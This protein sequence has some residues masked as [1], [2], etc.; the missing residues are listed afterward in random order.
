MNKYYPP[1]EPENYYHIYNHAVGR[2]NIFEQ[3]ENYYYFLEKY[4][5]HLSEVVDTYAY[6]LMPNHFHL[7]VKIKD[8]NYL[9]NFYKKPYQPLTKFKTLSKVNKVNNYN[10]PDPKS[11]SLLISK[12]FSNFFSSYSQ[13]FNKQQNRRGSLFEKP[14]RR[15]LITSEAYLKSLIAYIHYNPVHHGFVKDI[16]DWKHSSFE[17]FFIN[18]STL[19]K[20]HEVLNWYKDKNE[21]INTHHQKF[22]EKLF[23]EIEF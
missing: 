11:I 14:F 13:A 6:C 7:A 20:K 21:F 10:T 18:K 3:E 2:I 1:I 19:L 16:R 15:K 5:E 17:S 22:E 4:K 8:Y 12:S 23:S 9:L